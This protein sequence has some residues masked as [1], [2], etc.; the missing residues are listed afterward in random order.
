MT[1]IEKNA[2]NKFELWVKKAD[3]SLKN[4]LIN[5]KNDKKE[6]LDRF[7]K[8]LEFGTGGLRGKIGAGTNRMNVHTV[9]RA[10]QGFANYLKK[11]CRFPAVAIAYDTRKFS[12]DFAKTAAS[13][14]AANGINVHIFKE[15]TATP[16]LSFAVRYLKTT[17]GI[18]ITASHNPPQYNGYKIYTSDGTQAIPKV[19]NKVIEEINKLDYFDDVKITDFEEGIKSGYINWISEELFEDYINNLESYLRS[20]M[21]QMENNINIVY[22]PFHGTG[23]KPV[24]EILTRLGFNLKIV[25]EQAVPDPNFSTVK[26]PNPE[27]KD[28]FELALNYANNINADLVMATD[29]D[30]DRLGIYVKEGNDYK[31]FTG[32]QI[33]VMLSHF[34]L[35]RMQSL[36]IL[37]ENG[38]IIKTIV[39]TD[40]IKPIAREFNISVEE[41]LTGFKF[42]GEKL[43]K[44]YNNGEKKFIFGFEES[45]GYLA[46]DHARDK[47]AVIASGLVAIMVS[48]I[49]NKNMTLTDYFNELKEKYGYY[50]EEN[51]SFTLEGIEGLNKINTI[52]QKLRNNPPTQVKNLKLMEIIDYLKGINDLPQSNVVEL[53]YENKLKIIGRPSGTEPKIKFYLLAKGNNEVEAKNIISGAKEVVNSLT[54]Y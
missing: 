37:P 54:E 13:V 20:L 46:N 31:A 16:I 2:Y 26:V 48:Y 49:H 29:P 14:L 53:N 38:L 51:V 45:Y 40:M 23:L 21:P 30:S 7:F 10:T 50:L 1:D 19:A 12:L 6:L 39:T 32:N 18:V 24:K 44:Y 27:E 41:T 35:T 34:I 47:D 15:V 17:A 28:A 8:D 33:G 52:M 3:S 22:S 25:E 36:G 11:I 42:I 43:E 9:A 4:E 5:I